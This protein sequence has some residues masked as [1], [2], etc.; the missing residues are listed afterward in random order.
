MSVAQELYEGVELGGEYG[1]TGLITYMRTDSLRLSDEATA[2]AA[3]YIQKRYGEQFYPGK[4]RVF[5]TKGAAQDAHEAI[6]PSNVEIE[7]EA[8]RDQL[9][10]DQY[11]LY[12]LIWSRFVA[13][14]M[15]DA[16]L[17]TISA[18]I[19]SEGHIFRASG[20]TVAFPGF[21]AVYEAVSYTH[22][23]F[24]LDNLPQFTMA[25]FQG[26]MF[27]VLGIFAG[28]GVILSLIHIYLDRRCT[29]RME[30]LQDQPARYP[31]FLRFRKRSQ[32]GTA[33]VRVRAD[34]CNR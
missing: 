32:S 7:P 18:D 31:G 11:K 33:R 15:A 4:P 27:Y 6:R 23:G 24:I 14:Q 21:T 30:R 9:T 1:L 17:D 3:A 5:K 13:C 19:T 10:P 8:V 20:H 28:A 26:L 16:I 2:A 22:L 12:K 25:E 34:R 29:G